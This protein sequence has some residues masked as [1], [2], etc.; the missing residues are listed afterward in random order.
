MSS[1]RPVATDSRAAVYTMKVGREGL[2]TLYAADLQGK[3]LAISFQTEAEV[4]FGALAAGWG[5]TR[6]DV[7]EDRLAMVVVV[8]AHAA[9]TV[10][11]AELRNECRRQAM[12]CKPAYT[13]PISGSLQRRSSFLLHS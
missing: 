8:P 4:R 6:L 10:A 12:H 7:L 9:L 11:Y 2:A 5:G 3:N 13:R 1:G